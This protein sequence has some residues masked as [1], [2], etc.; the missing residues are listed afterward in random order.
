MPHQWGTPCY[1]PPKN[2]KTQRPLLNNVSLTSETRGSAYLSNHQVCLHKAEELHHSDCRPK[3]FFQQLLDRPPEHIKKPQNYHVPIFTTCQN[4]YHA[5]PPTQ[6]L[7]WVVTVHDRLVFPETVFVPGA[8]PATAHPI[9]SNRA[10]PSQG[11]GARVCL[12]VSE[13]PECLHL[14]CSFQEALKTSQS[15]LSRTTQ[16]RKVSPRARL[17]ILHLESSY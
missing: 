16:N 8:G 15:E 5:L 12:T 13:A 3:I 4:Y 10:L 9:S 7:L 17:T 1:P 11:R 6:G 2:N 14:S